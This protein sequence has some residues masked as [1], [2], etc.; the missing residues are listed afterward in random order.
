MI[1]LLQS[2][3]TVSRSAGKGGPST[4]AQETQ[5]SLQRRLLSSQATTSRLQ[6]CLTSLVPVQTLYSPGWPAK[7]PLLTTSV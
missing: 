2:L 3:E 6:V 5:D 1:H 7:I 4:E